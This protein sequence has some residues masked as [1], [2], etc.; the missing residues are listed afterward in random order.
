MKIKVFAWNVIERGVR[1]VNQKT[2]Q[3]NFQC[4]SGVRHDFIKNL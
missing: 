4:K 1:G 3:L 2:V